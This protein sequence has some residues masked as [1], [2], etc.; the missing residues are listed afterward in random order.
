MRPYKGYSSDGSDSFPSERGPRRGPT[1]RSRRSEGLSP[2]RPMDRRTWWTIDPLWVGLDEAHPVRTLLLS[3]FPVF[4]PC[5][6]YVSSATA[7]FPPFLRGAICYS[8]NTTPLF[9]SIGKTIH[10]LGHGLAI[11]T[12]TGAIKIHQTNT[13]R[14]VQV[15]QS[16]A[17]AHN[18]RQP[19]TPRY[20]QVSQLIVVAEKHCQGFIP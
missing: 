7:V 11:D 15:S 20:V 2:E 10:Q 4:P 16:I 18:I 14:Y 5:S 13:P 1:H 9:P 6:S 12:I 19:S 17:V 3:N 8:K